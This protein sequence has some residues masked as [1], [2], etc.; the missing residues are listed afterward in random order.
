[1]TISDG[2]CA[3]ADVVVGGAVVVVGACV[4]VGAVVL[5]GSVVVGA[6]VVVGGCE[7]EAGDSVVVAGGAPSSVG[8]SGATGAGLGAA[9]DSPGAVVVDVTVVAGGVSPESLF[10][11][12]TM[13]HTSS[14][15]SS[16][17]S[18]PQPI[19]ASGRRYQ[20]VGGGS[21]GSGQPGRG[22]GSRSSP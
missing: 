7:L 22:A 5:G 9:G 13:L 12:R 2:G 4:V 11:S 1:M 3:A 14:A 19:S 17:V 6:V 21:T 20:G 10:T 8:K 16:A 15:I 18:T